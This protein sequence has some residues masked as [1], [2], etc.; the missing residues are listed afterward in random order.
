MNTKELEIIRK[1]SYVER[2]HTIPTIGNQNL[3]HHCY[4]VAMIALM[5]EEN[6]SARLMKACLLHDVHEVHDGDIPSP[7]IRADEGLQEAKKRMENR[8]NTKY[9]T[10]VHLNDYEKAVLSFADKAELAYFCIDQINMGNRNVRQCLTRVLC[11][12]M[13]IPQVGRSKL[14]L[15]DLN[16]KIY[17]LED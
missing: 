4:N 12:M 2:L 8:F 1:S 5:I 7:S 15:D 10:R 16:M 6:A 14:I 17:L 3:G 9:N 13:E 11:Y